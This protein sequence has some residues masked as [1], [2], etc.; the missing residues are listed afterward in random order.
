MITVSICLGVRRVK[1][2]RK[3]RIRERLLAMLAVIRTANSES[4]SQLADLT[5]RNR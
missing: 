2:A 3:A 4:I 1:G 5:A